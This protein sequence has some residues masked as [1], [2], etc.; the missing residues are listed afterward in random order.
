MERWQIQLIETALAVVI[1]F[2]A[3][4]A[5]RT[6]VKR[7][8]G[9]FNYQITRISLIKRILEF[10]LIVVLG[11][12][13]LL[14]W[15]VEQSKLVFFFTSLLTVLGIAF[16]AQWSIISNITSSIIIFFNHPVKI[17]DYIQVLDKEFEIKG[18]VLDIGL[19]FLIIETED[20]ERVTIP[21]NVFMQ[22]MIKRRE[23]NELED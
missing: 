4:I 23:S 3:R 10:N 12:F 19:F 17:G 15:G 9:R 18:N 6:V 13:V 16:F 21:S 14:V 5:F 8:G 11:A 1:Y 20:H 2:M 7:V 22:K